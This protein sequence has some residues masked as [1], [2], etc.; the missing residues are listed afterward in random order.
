MSCSCNSSTSTSTTSQIVKR[1][2][3]GDTLSL[4][5]FNGSIPTDI[6][7]N[8]TSTVSAII[9]NM[10]L[11]TSTIVAIPDLTNGSNFSQAVVKLVSSSAYL[12]G[13][14]KVLIRSVNGTNQ[15][16]TDIGIYFTYEQV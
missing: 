1:F 8:A 7:I 9:K 14:Y 5:I 6:T 16:T 3:V 10:D 13:N 15:R 4:D 11:N 12:V 2:Y